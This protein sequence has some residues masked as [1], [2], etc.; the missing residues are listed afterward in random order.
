MNR[1][2]L[3]CLAINVKKY[4][5]LSRSFWRK[6]SMDHST[7]CQLSNC[8]IVKTVSICISE[9]FFVRLSEFLIKPQRNNKIENCIIRTKTMRWIRLIKLN[10]NTNFSLF[11]LFLPLVTICLI[12][13]IR[14][15]IIK[16]SNCFIS[17]IKNWAIY[18]SN[19]KIPYIIHWLSVSLIG[20]CTCSLFSFYQFSFCV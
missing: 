11:L 10:E 3:S 18:C 4:V 12:V 2:R 6:C 16:T 1:S 17:I 14:A 7:M 13:C 9:R 5:N 19:W 15:R 20:V 8:R